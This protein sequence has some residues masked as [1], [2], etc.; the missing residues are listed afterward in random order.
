MTSGYEELRKILGGSFVVKDIGDL[1]NEGSQLD[2]LGRT[3]TRNGDEVH[4]KGSPNYTH[5]RLEILHRTRANG[6]ETTGSNTAKLSVDTDNALTLEAHSL[7]RTCVGKL[8]L[9]VPIRLDI[10]YA[11]KELARGLHSPT[12]HSWANL[13]R[14]GSNFQGTRSYVLSSRPKLQLPG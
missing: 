5:G 7:Y 11:V 6:S 4:V 8:Q 2:F 9:L 14:L 12:K 1:S 3:L 10:A 13:R